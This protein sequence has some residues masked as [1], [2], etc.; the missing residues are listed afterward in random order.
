MVTTRIIALRRPC[1]TPPVFTDAFRPRGP[2]V[3]LAQDIDKRGARKTRATPDACRRASVREGKYN[4]ASYPPPRSVASRSTE[5]KICI[6]NIPQAK[7]GKEMPVTASVILTGQASDYAH[8]GGDADRHARTPIS[9]W[10]S[11]ATASAKSGVLLENRAAGN[12][13]VC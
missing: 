6:N 10:L 2:H 9:Y 13:R 11:S 12:S 3:I 4:V 1:L 5:K 8:G 7:A